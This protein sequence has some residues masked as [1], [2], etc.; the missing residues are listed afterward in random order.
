MIFKRT[1]TREN[2]G[3][4]VNVEAENSMYAYQ[5]LW[6]VLAEFFGRKR[7]D[8]QEVKY[9]QGVI[10]GFQKRWSLSVFESE[11]IVGKVNITLIGSGE[12][13]HMGK[14]WTEYKFLVYF[15]DFED[16]IQLRNQFLRY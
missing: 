3:V 10:R 13:E 15:E 6:D 7:K 4:I 11:K 2:A 12:Q 5:S 8:L 16:K 1:P 9:E 14:R